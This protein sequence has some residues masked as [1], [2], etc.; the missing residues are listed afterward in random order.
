VHFVVVDGGRVVDE[1]AEVDLAQ[2]MGDVLDPSH[3]SGDHLHRNDTGY[4]AMADAVN[5]RLL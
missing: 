4:R 1:A 2:A 5:L 3:D